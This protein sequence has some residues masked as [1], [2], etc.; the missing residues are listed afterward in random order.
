MGVVGRPEGAR[1]GATG[2]SWAVSSSQ[3]FGH[4]IKG[5]L[6]RPALPQRPTHA[7]RLR[8]ELVTLKGAPPGVAEPLPACVGA[9][10]IASGRAVPWLRRAP[11]RGIGGSGNSA[12]HKSSGSPCRI[13]GSSATAGGRRTWWAC[14]RRGRARRRRSVDREPMTRL[15]APHRPARVECCCSRTTSEGKHFAIGDAAGNTVHTDGQDQTSK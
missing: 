9:I 13:S 3:F 7:L 2:A 6:P 12:R 4:G 11:G 5:W 15:Q 14:R 1:R 8:R 10:E